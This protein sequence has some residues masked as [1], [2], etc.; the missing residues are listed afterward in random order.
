MIQGRSPMQDSDSVFSQAAR[1]ES[2]N[3]PF[4]LVTLTRT[5]G[6]TPRNNGRMLVQA[7][8]TSVGTVGGGAAEAY[9]VSE[10]VRMIT[11]GTGGSISYAIRFDNGHASDGKVEF[12]VDVISSVQK[13]ILF[14]GGHVGHAIAELAAEVGFEVELVETRPEFATTERFPMASHIH[15]APTINESLSK[16]HITPDTAI[17]VASHAVDYEICLKV[18]ASDARYIGMLGS[19]EKAKELHGKLLES[20]I[21]LFQIDRLYTPIGLDIGTETPRQIAVAVV[22]EIMQVMNGAGGGHL[23]D[24]SRKN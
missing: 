14:G 2:L 9:A 4:A 3:I 16:L 19:K 7:D 10:A 15:V 17:V 22:A 12:F 6:T 18:L 21:P 8:G 13:L 20:G 5:E 23:R 24:V 11:S 1:L